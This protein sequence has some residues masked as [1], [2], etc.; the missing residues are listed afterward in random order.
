MESFAIKMTNSAKR[1]EGFGY[2]ALL[3][4]GAAGGGGGNL[5]PRT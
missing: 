4:T 1:N 2:R 5:F 3:I